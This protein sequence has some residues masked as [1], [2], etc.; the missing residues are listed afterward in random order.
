MHGPVDLSRWRSD[1][2]FMSDPTPLIV[3]DGDFIIRATN[4]AHERTMGFS[5]DSLAGRSAFEAFPANPADPDGDGQLSVQDAWERVLREGRSLDLVLQR[6]DIPDAADPERFLERYWLPVSSP[7]RDGDRVVG[8]SMRSEPVLLPRE[9]AAL[10][11]EFRAV[12]RDN[13]HDDDEVRRAVEAVVA[14]LRSHGELGRTVSQLQEA[15]KSRATIEQAKGIVMSREGVDADA[16]FR[17]L[18]RMSNESNVR[19]ADVASAL[20]YQVSRSGR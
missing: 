9:V 10:V 2:D 3:V 4:P 7:V 17:L 14:G 11:H 1:E 12:L 8:I 19:L 18:V 5:Y 15:M 13:Q 6:Y 20:V 16:A